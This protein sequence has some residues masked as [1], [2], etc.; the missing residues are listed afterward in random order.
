MKNNSTKVFLHATL[1]ENCH[2]P[3]WF[4]LEKIYCSAGNIKYFKIPMEWRIHN[5]KSSFVFKIPTFHPKGVY[6]GKDENYKFYLKHILVTDSVTSG[7]FLILLD[8]ALDLLPEIKKYIEKS[9]LKIDYL[10][11]QQPAYN[12]LCPIWQ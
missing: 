1:D 3:P 10:K 12:I 6:V 9:D 8:L 7:T 11:I 2:L 4:K 5:E